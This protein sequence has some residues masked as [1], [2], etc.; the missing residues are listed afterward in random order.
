MILKKYGLLILFKETEISLFS[1]IW[2]FFKKWVYMS[3]Y[4]NTLRLRNGSS[5]YVIRFGFTW[6]QRHQ[7]E[8]FDQSKFT[9]C[10]N[11]E[12]VF[13]ICFLLKCWK[14]ANVMKLWH[15]VKSS[16]DKRSMTWVNWATCLTVKNFSFWLHLKIPFPISYQL[17][18]FVT[19]LFL[20]LEERIKIYVFECDPS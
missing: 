7:H 3:H 9:I 1:K 11:F 13:L 8:P 16:L 14:W 5:Y 20:I 10:L 18:P 17:L 12:N 2:K 19:F 4:K 6:Q 15:Q